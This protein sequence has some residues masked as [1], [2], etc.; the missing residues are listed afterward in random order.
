MTFTWIISQ[1]LVAMVSWISPWDFWQSQLIRLHLV[2]DLVI[3]LVYFSIPI[4]FIYFVRQRQ[5]L[6]Y[7]SVFILFSIFIFAFGINHLMAILTL[8][9][10]VYW[11]SGG[12]KAIP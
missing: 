7:S 1:Q 5:N 4:S 9:Y 8:W 12:L 2:S 11:L 10:P 6:S 3:A